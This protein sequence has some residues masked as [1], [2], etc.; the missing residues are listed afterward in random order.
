MAMQITPATSWIQGAS[1]DPAAWAPTG[2]TPA[3]GESPGGVAERFGWLAEA[4]SLSP[5]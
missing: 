3:A 1:G 2:A 5:S 4:I